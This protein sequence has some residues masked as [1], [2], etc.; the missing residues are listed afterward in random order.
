M[1]ISESLVREIHHHIRSKFKHTAKAD[2]KSFLDVDCSFFSNAPQTHS[3]ERKELP[4][5]L[6]DEKLTGL[7]IQELRRRGFSIPGSASLE[8]R[9]RR[10]DNRFAAESLVEAFRL[11]QPSGNDYR[12]GE[13]IMRN[14]VAGNCHEMSAAAAWYALQKNV[15][16]AFIGFIEDPGDHVFCLICSG[17]APEWRTVASTHKDRSDAWVIDVWA[18]VCCPLWQ[19]EMLF[20]LKMVQWRNEGKRVLFEWVPKGTSTMQ[21]GWIFPDS[22]DYLKAFKNGKLDFDE[23]RKPSR[24]RRERK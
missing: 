9:L 21:S 1:A 12:Y 19:Y 10:L 16:N 18:N 22:P 14:P 17:E 13:A 15:G 7:S 6:L 4:Q 3:I 20:T 5:L 23:V 11:K 8:K 2:N 24:G